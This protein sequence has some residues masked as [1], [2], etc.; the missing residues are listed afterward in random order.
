MAPLMTVRPWQ[1]APSCGRSTETRI[2]PK[3]AIL[4]YENRDD[5]RLT[6]GMFFKWEMNSRLALRSKSWMKAGGIVTAVAEIAARLQ[7]WSMTK[8]MPPQPTGC[9]GPRDT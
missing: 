5:Y 8:V 1:L 9:T 3:A 4:P 2:D 7:D 6:L